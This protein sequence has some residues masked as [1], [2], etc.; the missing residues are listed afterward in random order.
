[1]KL[2]LEANLLL[3]FSATI[4]AAGER[5]FDA[6]GWRAAWGPRLRVAQSLVLA[7]L[8]FPAAISLLPSTPLPEWKMPS[9]R[10]ERE[11]G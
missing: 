9:F 5:V 10:S 6:V 3:V 2:F 1:M 8:L 11:T 4:F 7:S